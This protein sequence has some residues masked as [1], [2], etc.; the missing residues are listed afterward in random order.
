MNLLKNILA[1]A[2]ISGIF[3]LHPSFNEGDNF[4]TKIQHAFYGNSFRVIINSEIEPE[5]LKVVWIDAEQN[6]LLIYAF[7]KEINEIP[8]VSGKQKLVVYYQNKIVGK[9]EQNKPTPFQ[10]HKY[11]LNVSS[12]NN[13]IFFKGEI[14]GPSGVKSPATTTL[15][16]ASL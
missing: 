16:I 10:A 12:K 7:G 9:V 13:A 8:S 15:P 1:Y 6:E 3:L 14:S 4:I 2:C 11:S 5:K